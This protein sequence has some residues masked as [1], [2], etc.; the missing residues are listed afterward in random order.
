MTD[1]LKRSETGPTTVVAAER[2]VDTNSTVEI[3]SAI[4]LERHGV[5]TQL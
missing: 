5:D 3:A 4:L 2:T 1:A